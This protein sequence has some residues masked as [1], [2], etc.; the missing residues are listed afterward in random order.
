[1]HQK[2]PL[3]LAPLFA[4]SAVISFGVFASS[5]AASLTVATVPAQSCTTQTVCGQNRVTC[6]F[7]GGSAF[8][9]TGVAGAFFDFVSVGC[10]PTTL[11]IYKSSYTGSVTT[12]STT[13]A[14]GVGQTDAWLTATYT[15]ASPSPYDYWWVLLQTSATS[16]GFS[17]VTG[18]AFRMN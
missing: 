18:A 5:P 2:T 3:T 15:G 6:G 7:Q 4:L 13:N 1:M 8:S 16:P 10:E 11:I 9:A 12:D 17:S 14:F